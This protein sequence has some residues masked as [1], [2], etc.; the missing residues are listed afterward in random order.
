MVATSLS[1]GER[2]SKRFKRQHWWKHKRLGEEWR[3]P[4]GKDSKMRLGIKGK[5][6]VVSVGYRTSREN[7]G[8]HPCGLHEV[9]VRNLRDLERV[10]PRRQVARISAT[11]GQRLRNRI[12]Q[13]ARELG[14]K[15]LNPR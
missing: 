2:V 7:R 8:L 14:I 10:D 9:L 13:R 5:P 15:V 3:R 4:R 6:P 1:G 11:V 12:L